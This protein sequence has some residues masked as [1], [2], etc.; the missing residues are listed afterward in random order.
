M[1]A[2]VGRELLQGR[3]GEGDRER[4]TVN[5]RSPKDCG[6]DADGGVVIHEPFGRFDLAQVHGAVRMDVPVGIGRQIDVQIRTVPDRARGVG[7]TGTG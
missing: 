3:S 1:S 2:E 5:D 6:I 7:S 4:L